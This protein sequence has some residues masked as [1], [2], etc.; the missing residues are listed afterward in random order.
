MIVPDD[1][2]MAAEAIEQQIENTQARRTKEIESI[3]EELKGKQE[4]ELSVLGWCK[5]SK[6]KKLAG[7]LRAL[8]GAKVSC[9]RPRSVPSAS[10]HEKM[11]NEL[12]KNRRGHLKAIDNGEGILTAKES[13]LG[14]L[15]EKLKELETREVA[16]EMSSGLDGSV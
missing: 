6:R 16:R 13:E 5:T 4:A 9:S 15:K 10:G 14:A 7:V 1:D 11:M 8:E 12:D 3:N 2:F